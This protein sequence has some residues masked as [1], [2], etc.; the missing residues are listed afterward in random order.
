MP[1]D[2]QITRAAALKEWA[3]LLDDAARDAYRSLPPSIMATASAV[4][5]LIRVA[6][7]AADALRQM[8]E[9]HG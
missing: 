9:H 7:N 1:T 5:R 6:G 8:D 2:E 3:D 4:Q